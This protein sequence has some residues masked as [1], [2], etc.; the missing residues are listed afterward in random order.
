MTRQHAGV[1]PG[2]QL[3]FAELRRGSPCSRLQDL[4]SQPDTI[5]SSFKARRVNH[6]YT[7]GS[8]R[9]AEPHPRNYLTADQKMGNSSHGHPHRMFTPP[10][11]LPRL[12][13]CC[14]F[15]V[16]RKRGVCNAQARN[17]PLR[18]GNRKRNAMSRAS[19]LSFQAEKRHQLKPDP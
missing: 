11:F 6:A 16:K 10:G 15:A 13:Q 2:D 1:V 3:V 19:A 8:L 5:C 17:W 14:Q 12:V 4:V 7:Q 18:F 9:G